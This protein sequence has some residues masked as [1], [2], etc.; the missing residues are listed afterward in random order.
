MLARLRFKGDLRLTMKQSRHT[1]PF[2]LNQVLLHRT[3]R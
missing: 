1:I 3:L 2:S